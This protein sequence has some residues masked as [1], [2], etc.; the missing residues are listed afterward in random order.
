MFLVIDYLVIDFDQ[1]TNMKRNYF[2][3]SCVQYHKTWYTLILIN[4]NKGCFHI[5]QKKMTDPEKCL[6]E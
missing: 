5:I 6:V 2:F 1:L 4:T 3:L